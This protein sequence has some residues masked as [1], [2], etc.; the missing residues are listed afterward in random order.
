M[1]KEKRLLN[2]LIRSAVVSGGIIVATAGMAYFSMNFNEDLTKEKRQTTNQQRQLIA[3]NRAAI[4][5]HRKAE[6]SLELYERLMQQNGDETLSLD[7]RKV[8]QLLNELNQRYRLSGLNLSISPPEKK[9]NSDFS[10]A[11][12]EVFSSDVRISFQSISDEF[13]FGLLYDMVEKFPGLVSISEF[14]LARKDDVTPGIVSELQRGRNTALV[15]GTLTFN[16]LGLKFE[17]P[18]EESIDE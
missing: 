18:E 10:V 7:R 16:W 2:Q 13:A 14:Q 1:N 8:T 15:R 6:T 5:K 3:Q 4:D 11:S 17:K 9:N 12:G